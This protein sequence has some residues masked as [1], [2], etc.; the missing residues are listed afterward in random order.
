MKRLGHS[1]QR[2]EG[3]FL[4]KK[5]KKRKKKRKKKSK[6]QSMKKSMVL[7]SFFLKIFFS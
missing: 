2:K 5:Q 1:D 7:F 6:K 4:Q 3:Y